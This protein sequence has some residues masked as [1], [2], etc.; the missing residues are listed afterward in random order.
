MG[1]PGQVLEGMMEGRGQCV[2]PCQ[3]PGRDHGSQAGSTARGSTFAVDDNPYCKHLIHFSLRSCLHAAS[4]DY[5]TFYGD[6]FDMIAAL[7]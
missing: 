4:S 5:S 3:R 1:D 6:I 2:Q 7:Q